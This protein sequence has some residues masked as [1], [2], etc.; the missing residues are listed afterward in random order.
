LPSKSKSLLRPCL[1][2]TNHAALTSIEVEALRAEVAEGQAQLLFM[3]E[4]LEELDAQKGEASAAIADAQRIMHIQKNSTQAEVYKLSR[5]YLFTFSPRR[6]VDITNISEE[7]EG[8][9]D[10]H[11]FRTTKVNADLFEYVYA[12]QLRVSIPCRKFMPIVTRVEMTRLD[13]ARSRF[14]DDF[15]RLSDFLLRMAKQQVIHKKD[16]A[17]REVSF[18]L[19]LRSTVNIE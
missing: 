1:R 15:P 16:P 7:L 6:A 13:K 11:M 19:L 17:V 14:K 5:A 18:A 3:E 2:R 9:E 10:L 8:L 12:S 4:K